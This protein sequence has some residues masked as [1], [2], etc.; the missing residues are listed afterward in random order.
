M[1]VSSWCVH[2]QTLGVLV[3]LKHDP[4]TDAFD[5]AVDRTQD[6]SFIRIYSCFKVFNS[7]TTIM[8]SSA[9]LLMIFVKYIFNVVQYFFTSGR[10]SRDTIEVL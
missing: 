4:E 6:F 5:K 1:S 2:A 10:G 8:G 7:R 9:V 3:M